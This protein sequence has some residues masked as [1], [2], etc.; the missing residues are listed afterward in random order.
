[1]VRKV[2]KEKP[3]P[4]TSLGSTERPYALEWELL[5]ANH[6]ADY[7]HHETRDE[8][9]LAPVSLDQRRRAQEE[10]LKLLWRIQG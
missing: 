9:A 1:M 6:G 7:N 8:E 2:L 10:P 4:R 5:D 3:A